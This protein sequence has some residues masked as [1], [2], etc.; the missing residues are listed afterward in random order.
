MSTTHTGARPGAGVWILSGVV[1][2]VIAGIIFAVFEMVLAAIMGQGF[3]APLRMIGAI[4]LGEGALEPAYSLATAGVTGLV[5]HMMMSAL[6]GAV[7]AAVVLRV[8]A[9]RTSRA[10]ITAVATAF[11]FALWIVNFYIFAPVL[12]PWFAMANPVVQFFAHTFFFGTALGLLLAARRPHE[13][14]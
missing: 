2:G 6:Y 8:A 3:F 11:G 12:F 14:L 1:M 7:F 13:E 9:L 4:A 5:V 10:A